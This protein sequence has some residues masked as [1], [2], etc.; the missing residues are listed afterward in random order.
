MLDPRRP[1]APPPL[2][3]SS[4]G[5]RTFLLLLLCVPMGRG[6]ALLLEPWLE[7]PLLASQPHCWAHCGPLG[8]GGA[9]A[10]GVHPRARSFCAL[11][12]LQHPG[13]MMVMPAC[14]SLSSLPP[15]R[16]SS[17]P[18]TWCTG[19]R[20]SSSTRCVRTTSTCSPPTPAFACE[21]HTHTVLPP[22]GGGWTAVGAPRPSFLA[23]TR[24]VL[25]TQSGPPHSLG[26]RAEYRITQD[27][28]VEVALL[29]WFINENA[30]RKQKTLV[31]FSWQLG[32]F[33]TIVKKS[34]GC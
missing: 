13:G 28:T 7:K 15:G 34:A 20:P 32:C 26:G 31:S 2:A 14:P 17:W 25:R 22:A 4:S 8:G 27:P 1:S 21:H 24:R 30:Q 6:G 9:A 16:S 18:L 3:F 29:N 5:L 19:A 10:A 11:Y 23:Y 12:H 33:K